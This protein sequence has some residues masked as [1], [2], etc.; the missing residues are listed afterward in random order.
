[1]TDRFAA[2]LA[3]FA[4]NARMSLDR[5]ARGITIKWFSSTIAST[6]VDTGRLRGNWQCTLSSPA[7]GELPRLDLTGAAA[8]GD[9][10]RIVGGA[11]SLNYLTNNMQ[12]ARKIEYGGSRQAPQGMVRINFLRIKSIVEEVAREV[13]T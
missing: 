11:G 4:R 9:V 5:A 3:A 12:Y 13:R 7:T 6:P 2:D 8:I 1:M 10:T